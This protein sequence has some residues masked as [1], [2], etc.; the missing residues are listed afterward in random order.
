ARDPGPIGQ[1]SRLGE[2]RK[3]AM[4]N[5]LLTCDECG[6]ELPVM[7]EGA[8]QCPR[9][10]VEHLSQTGEIAAITERTLP[11][12]RA[13]H[14]GEDAARIPMSEEAILDLLRRH[15]GAS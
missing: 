3:N 8:V 9:C 11:S 10:G 12:D 13:S 14:D 7:S 6:T 5:D 15:F 1:E 2:R 4:Q